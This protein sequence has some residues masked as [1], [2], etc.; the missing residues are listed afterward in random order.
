MQVQVVRVASIP[1]ATAWI[2]DEPT[3]RTVWLLEEH[4]T[5]QGAAALEKKLNAD[6]HLW[7]LFVA[8]MEHPLKR[9]AQAV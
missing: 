2:E 9:F 7:D 6:S 1:H 4:I 5:A 8:F 3:G